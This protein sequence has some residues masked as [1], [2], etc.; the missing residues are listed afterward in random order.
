VGTGVAD[1][2]AG[3]AI[4]ITVGP[5]DSGSG[6]IL[7]MAAGGTTNAGATGGHV[8]GAAGAASAGNGGQVGAWL[9]SCCGCCWR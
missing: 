9:T 7:Q 5:T 1:G 3:G 6:S 8:V 4:S 2:G